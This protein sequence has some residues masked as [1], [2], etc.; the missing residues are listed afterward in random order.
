MP[1]QQESTSVE[2]VV[3]DGQAHVE[4][5]EIVSNP[6]SSQGKVVAIVPRKSRTPRMLRGF[7]Y[8]PPTIGRIAIGEVVESNGKRLPKKL[9]EIVITTQFKKNGKWVEHPLGESLRGG[10][11][12]KKLREI[13]VRLLFD[14]PDLSFR[15]SYELFKDS[16]QVCVGNGEHSK[17]RVD[18]VL[19]SCDC[20]GPDLCEF[21]QKQEKIKCKPFARL[22]VQIEGQDDE[23]S[24][25][26]FR[27]TGWN[28][29]RTLRT[30]L[31]YLYGAFN[32]ELAGLPLTLLMR[33]K[34]TQL[35]YNAP[36]FYLDLVVKGKSDQAIAEQNKL[37]S[38]S[39][40]DYA[41]LEAAAARGLANG[42]FEET[43]DE[44]LDV[45]DWMIDSSGTQGEGT[46][47][48][49]SIFEK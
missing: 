22:N 10:D 4:E 7:S 39:G 1:A 26:V 15:E 47:L 23:L 9:D 45:E 34:S 25:F 38:S 42:A 36:F 11:A 40:L 31:E 35:S 8:V 20:P 41:G 16:R 27:T 14:D 33:G 48:D 21:S 37:R 29:I 19:E 44:S 6:Q 30:K 24:T 46:V 13:P 12:N 17:R 2:D 32:G 18:G 5:V 28:S 49:D 43:E 3:Y